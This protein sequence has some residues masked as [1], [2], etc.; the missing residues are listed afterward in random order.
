MNTSRPTSANTVVLIHGL[1]V[2]PLCWEHWIDR[3]S[4]RGHKVLAPAWPGMEAGVEQLRAD[5][6]TIDRLGKSQAWEISAPR[7]P[8]E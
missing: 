4:A 2:T 5:P 8:I 1:W 6:R 3:Y 7:Y